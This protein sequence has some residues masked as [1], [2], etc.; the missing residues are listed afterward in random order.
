MHIAISV[1][2]FF[3]CP[4]LGLVLLSASLIGSLIYYL[5][6]F[7]IFNLKSNHKKAHR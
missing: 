3:I 7:I 2:I 6:S 5:F 1:M 4:E